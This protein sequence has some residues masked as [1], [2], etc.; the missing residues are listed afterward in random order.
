MKRI[1]GNL[2]LDSNCARLMAVFPSSSPGF[3]A[4]HP[5]KVP[6]PFCFCDSACRHLL[7]L[8][9]Y[10]YLPFISLLAH[11]LEPPFLSS[12][13]HC[14]YFLS[15]FLPSIASLLFIVCSCSTRFRDVFL[16][17]ICFLLGM[18]LLSSLVGRFKRYQHRGR[19]DFF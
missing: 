10:H 9:F 2:N 15:S 12:V 4:D 18:S 8:H 7:F 11:F 13:S 16:F 1:I 3:V 19:G 17:I 14:V 5:A 6:F